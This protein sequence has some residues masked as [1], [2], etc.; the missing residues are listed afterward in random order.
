M[1][2][3]E[4]PNSLGDGLRWEQSSDY[5]REKLTVISGQNLAVLAVVAIITASGKATA[6][7]PAESDGSEVAAGIMVSACD[8][9][10]ADTEG[11]AIVRDALIDEGSLAWP[12]G[13]SGGEKTQALT[14]L[15]A[16]GIHTRETA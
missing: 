14:E 10:S 13:I 2:S 6:L 3:L 7:A 15:A 4:Q 16:L 1:S 5:S 11:A 12:D 9:S 8:A